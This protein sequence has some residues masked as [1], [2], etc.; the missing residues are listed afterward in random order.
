MKYKDW[1]QT[2]L[3]LYVKSMV[4]IRTYEK[5][6]QIARNRIIPQL[7]E[8]NLDE[9]GSQKLQHYVVSLCDTF[10]ANSVNGTITVLQKSLRMAVML[11]AVD[12]CYVDTICRPQS[13]EKQVECFSV[14]EQ[15]KIEEY[16]IGGKKKKLYGII[17]C[18]YTGLR[19]GELLALEWSDIDFAKGYLFV[20]KS[21]HYGKDKNGIYGR[22]VE[23]PKTAQS[24]RIIPIP[25]AL[26]PYLKELK[27]NSDGPYV[28]SHNSKPIATRSYQN[29]FSILL[30]K[31]K[32][33]HKGFHSLRH[34]FAT[35]ALESGMDIKTLS[36]LMGHKNPT[37]TLKRYAHSMLEHKTEMMNKLGRF[38]SLKT[39]EN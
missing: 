7:G 33:E 3:D 21:C 34:T 31:L 24:I 8:E 17:I 30:D 20:N 9:L 12:K 37:V 16:I 26:I 18:L 28:I 39:P 38:C 4:K 2:W 22:I 15:R 35:R 23:K 1:I 13:E 27:K 25:K 10:A 5:Y 6:A 19:I 32:I 29:S 36:E 14:A 11:G